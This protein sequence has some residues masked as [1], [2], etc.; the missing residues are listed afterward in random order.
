[1]DH[2]SSVVEEGEEHEEED[3]HESHSLFGGATAVKFLLAGG[4]AGAGSS[5]SAVSGIQANQSSVSRTCTAPF[6]RLKIFLITRPPDLGGAK[7]TEGASVASPGDVSK[8]GVRGARALVGAVTR[9]YAEGGILAFWVGNGLS[10]AKIFP[11]SAIKFLAYES[12]VST[13]MLKTCMGLICPQK[14][15]F[16]RYW[17][18]VE[19]TRDISGVSRFVSGGL[20]GISSQ[21]CACAISIPR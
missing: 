13:I 2:T 16:A 1:V 6:D 19:D 3:H 4:I 15:A 12:S 9:I 7:L 17:D 10:V 21:L 8:A 18:H 20:G 14:K 5:S 11:E